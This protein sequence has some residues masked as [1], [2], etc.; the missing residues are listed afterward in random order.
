MK[1]SLTSLSLFLA[2]CLLPVILNAGNADEP[3]ERGGNGKPGERHAH[4]RAHMERIDTNGDGNISREEASASGNPERA[5]KMFDRLDANN[6][7]LISSDER[8]SAIRDKVGKNRKTKD[9]AATEC[10]NCQG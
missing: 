5:Q 10:S 3:R 4:I 7:G 8:R 9:G 6:D 1:K 2:T